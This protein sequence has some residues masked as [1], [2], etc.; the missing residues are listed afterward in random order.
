MFAAGAVLGTQAVIVSTLIGI[1][2]AAIGG[3]IIKKVTK[4]SKFAFGPFLSIGIAVGALWGPK[5]AQMYLNL[6]ATD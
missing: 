1:F 6:L 2:S 4:D 3:L 5:L